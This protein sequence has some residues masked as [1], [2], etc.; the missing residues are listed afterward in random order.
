[1][2]VRF[3]CACKYHAKRNTD[4]STCSYDIDVGMCKLS[5]CE[6]PYECKF[7]ESCTLF[8]EITSF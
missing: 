1:M 6:M 7:N 5:M 4:D 2:S 8:L 3:T